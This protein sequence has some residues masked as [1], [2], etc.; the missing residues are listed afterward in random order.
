VTAL[1]SLFQTV[2]ESEEEIIQLLCDLISIPSINT[3]KM[4]TGDELPVCEY[5]KSRLAEEG[6]E[7]TILSSAENRANLVARLPGD[8]GRPRLLYMAHTDVVPVEDESEWTVPPF[9][10]TVKDGRV[11]G[12]GAA[13]M[14]DML[15]AEAMAMIILK[16]AGV[17]LQGELIFAAGADEEAGGEYGFG[18][19]ARNAPEA[20]RAD[21]AVNEGGGSP[22]P[23]DKGLAYAIPV[24]EKGRLE[25]NITIQGRSGHAAAP[26]RS[27]NV[28]FKLAEILKR[29]DAYQPE[30]D[31]SQ[32]MFE[33]L[34]PLLGR[35]ASITAANVDAL[36]DAVA[37]QNRA[38]A[39]MLRGSSRMTFVPT[40]WSGGVKSNS[41]PGVCTLVCDVRTLP[42]QDEDYVRSQVEQI[43]SGLEGVSYTLSY[44]AIPST[45]PYDT[46]FAAAIRRAGEAA[47]G[48]DDIIW[49]PGLT[50]GFTDS[51]LVRPLGIVAYG[52]G[53]GHPDVDPN[54]PSGAHGVDESVDIRSLILKTK[55]L[56]ALAIDVLRAQAVG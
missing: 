35:E 14:K 39:S 17:Q 20:I 19:L 2:E 31:V 50:T 46:P 22:L 8:A 5:L 18:W 28:A 25:V 55:F 32:V 43:L 52:F 42:H 12:R 26:W 37:P 24:G 54:I 41:I 49:L 53:M 23:T 16:R 33:H 11:W 6:I 4:P 3:G 51:R 47:L 9:G 38:L 40:M 56:I 27:E 48:R 44:T 13:D 30:I 29:L 1:E 45:S 15:A 7:S 36:A 21:F 10:G 34:G